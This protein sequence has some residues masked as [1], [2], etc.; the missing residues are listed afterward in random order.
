MAITEPSSTTRT[1]PIILDHHLL[2]EPR[3]AER[4]ADV[5]EV[6]KEAGKKVL[7]V[8]EWFGKRPLVL[9]AAGMPEK[10]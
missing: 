3:Y 9:E 7:T 4:L 2:R 10:A 8:A 1:D 5:Y 6:A